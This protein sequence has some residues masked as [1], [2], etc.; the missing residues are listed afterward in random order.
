MNSFQQL[1]EKQKA[2]FATDITKSY[3]WRVD[4]LDRLTKMLKENAERFYATL[5]QDFKTAL[6]E[7]VFEV[8]APLI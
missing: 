6:P 8:G 3:E 5:G 2:Y 1:F 4:Q 7:Q